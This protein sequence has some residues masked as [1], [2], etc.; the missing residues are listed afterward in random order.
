LEFEMYTSSRYFASLV[1]ALF[2][3]STADAQ[4]LLDFEH[5]PLGVAPVD[6]GPL[7]NAYNIPGGTVRFYFDTNGNN[8]F[9]SATDARPAFEHIGGDAVDGFESHYS[10]QPDTA[11]PGYESQLGNWFLRTPNGISGLPPGPFIAAYS[12]SIPIRE[13]SGEIWD[14]DG[15]PDNGGSEQWRVDVLN[16][17]GAV[18]RTLLSPNGNIGGGLDSLDSLPW[19]FQFKGLP[20]GVTDLRLTYIGSKT[21][22]IGLAFNNFSPTE[23]VPEPSGSIILVATLGLLS[24]RRGRST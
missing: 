7:N 15:G 24:R 16:G 11:R 1:L 14:I 17:S 20:D 10:G 5:T 18:L 3:A 4:G 19:V 23:A 2:T 13:L 8:K 9:D 21:D 22:G 6:N 12:T